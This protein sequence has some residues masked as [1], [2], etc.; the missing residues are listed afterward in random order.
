MALPAAGGG[1]E[2][3]REPELA[4][5]CSPVLSAVMQVTSSGAGVVAPDC[6]F[7]Q[8]VMS[9]Q[10]DRLTGQTRNDEGSPAP[11]GEEELDIM[12]RGDSKEG[13][14]RFTELAAAT[15]RQALGLPE[16]TM[17]ADDATLSLPPMFG[18]ASPMLSQ[19]LREEHIDPSD[20]VGLSDDTN[21]IGSGAFGEV[22]AVSWRKSPAAAKI[23]HPSM[24]HEQKILFLRELE[25]ALSVDRAPPASTRCGPLDAT[26]L[27][28]RR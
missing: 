20:L 7:P 5:P 23:A 2:T 12:H 1:L 28:A 22:R 4:P 14:H 26:S 6:E 10:T 27:A 9:E 11:G 24:T 25:A 3:S 19:V 13:D 15:S 21:L 16:A 8:A 18:S 17:L